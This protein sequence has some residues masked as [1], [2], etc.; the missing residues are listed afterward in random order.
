MID[1]LIIIIPTH[2][3]QHYLRRV[4]KYYSLFPC[5]VYIC[6]SS[7]ERAE[8][9]CSDNISYRW[10]PQSNF[11][12]KVLDV[13]NETSADFYALSPDDDFLKEE[14]LMECYEV[15]NKDNG[16]SLGVG[17]IVAFNKPFDKKFFYIPEA[18]KMQG[19]NEGAYQDKL[20]Y[21]KAFENNYQNILWTL[22]RKEAIL[23]AFNCLSTCNFGNGNFIELL[24]G[25]E[26]LRLGKVYVS[27]NALNYTEYILGE[28]W[29]NSIPSINRNNILTISSLKSDV[30]KF[31]NYFNNDGGF[32]MKCFEYYLD[33]PYHPK[34]SIVKA[35]LKKCLS[36][37]FISLIN[38]LRNKKLSDPAM[39]NNIAYSDEVMA[40]RIQLVL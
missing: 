9:E 16:Y 7:K 15:M 27:R 21:A 12:G 2:N 38:K 33:A 10:V 22:F 19:I 37:T 13:L 14:T 17:K 39:P 40:D 4:V 30:I 6:D 1:N 34:F 26:S 25:I 11:Y 3:R 8:I 24:L 28:H 18:N 35:Y 23:N 29:G 5:K 20:D 36:T 31:K 32:A